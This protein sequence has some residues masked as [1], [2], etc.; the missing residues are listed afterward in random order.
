MAK[1][2]LESVYRQFAN[3]EALR[4]H[5]GDQ[6]DEFE[7]IL[8][9]DQQ[10]CD[11]EIQATR[12]YLQQIEEKLRK[13]I[14]YYRGRLNQLEETNQET[15]KRS[16]D[17]FDK[18]IEIV[19]E[20]FSSGQHF[21]GK[22][23]LLID[24]HRVRF[25][26]QRSKSFTTTSNGFK[27]AKKSCDRYRSSTSL[28]KISISCLSRRKR[29]R[30]HRSLLHRPRSSLLTT[31]T[32]ATMMIMTRN[33]VPKSHDDRKWSRRCASNEKTRIYKKTI[34]RKQT[35]TSICEIAEHLHCPF[36]IV[37]LVLASVFDRYVQRILLSKQRNA[38]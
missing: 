34:K 9:D 14:D 10:F 18:E 38:W 37:S 2:D 33:W 19:N 13:K 32:T 1:Q 17:Q 20:A 26:F 6:I 22:F 27:T 29:Q 11:K 16:T 25:L 12:D 28:M 15:Y 3:P 31:T 23:I 7:R 36:T 30:P 5:L 24:A 8:N 21:E 35:R 4:Q